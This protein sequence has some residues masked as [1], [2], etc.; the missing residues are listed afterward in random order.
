ML[1]ELFGNL[2][3]REATRDALGHLIEKYDWPNKLLERVFAK[4]LA[5][6]YAEGYA[7]GY[8]RGIEQCRAEGI[9]ETLEW[10]KRRDAAR[11]KNEPFDESPPWADKL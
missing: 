2:G 5:K 11:E 6:A 8:E 4:T 3:T 10:V 7:I 9:A 1:S